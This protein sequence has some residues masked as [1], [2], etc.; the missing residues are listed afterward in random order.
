LGVQAPL[1]GRSGEAVA[2]RLKIDALVDG[3]IIHMPGNF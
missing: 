3:S 2:D 1:L